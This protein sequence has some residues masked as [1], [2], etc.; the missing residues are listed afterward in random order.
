M[1]IVKYANEK[2]DFQKLNNFNN[3]SLGC[4]DKEIGYLP[5]FF[6]DKS[7]FGISSVQSVSLKLSRIKTENDFAII[8][9]DGYP[10]VLDSN[11]IPGTKHHAQKFTYVTDNIQVYPF[12]VP[13]ILDGEQFLVPVNSNETKFDDMLAFEYTGWSVTSPSFGVFIFTSQDYKSKNG[14]FDINGDIAFDTETLQIANPFDVNGDFYYFEEQATSIDLKGYY[15]YS[16]F[17]NETIELKSE[18][19]RILNEASEIP[20]SGYELL[21][22]PWVI[23]PND[24]TFL[25]RTA[26]CISQSSGLQVSDSFCEVPFLRKSNGDINA[27]QSDLAQA[28]NTKYDYVKNKSTEFIEPTTERQYVTQTERENIN[29]AVPYTGATSAVDLNSQLLT[30]RSLDNLD[31]AYLTILQ[32]ASLNVSYNNETQDGIYKN[33]FFDVNS[34]RFNYADTNSNLF[35]NSYFNWLE[36]SFS[37]A[38]DNYSSLLTRAGL[39][40]NFGDLKTTFKSFGIEYDNGSYTATTNFEILTGNRVL[41]FPDESGV[42]ATKEYGTLT[43]E[44]LTNKGANNGYCG[45]DSGGKVPLSNLPTTLLIYK[46]VW[47]ATSNTPTLL[48]TDLTKAGY[49]YNVSVAGTQF[50]I[51]FKLGD[52]A[53][54]NDS[55]VLE[56]SDN[57]DDVISVNGQQGV[58]VLTQDDIADGTNYKRVT[59]SEKNT[60]NAKQD[61]LTNPITGTGT[62]TQIAF[63]NGTTSLSS[64]ANFTFNSSTKNLTI[65]GGVSNLAIHTAMNKHGFEDYTTLNIPSLDNAGYS[66]YDSFVTC[67]NVGNINHFAAY[68]ARFQYAGSGNITNNC[69]GIGIGLTHSG[70]GVININRGVY[71]A[72]P[73]ITGAGSINYNYG[74]YIED[75]TTGAQLANYAIYVAGGKSQLGSTLLVTGTSPELLITETD[76]A[77]DSKQWD[78]LVNGGVL[79]HRIINDANSV[80]TTYMQ[81]WRS[82]TTISKIVFPN[83]NVA[84]GNLTPTSK[85]HL[86]SGNSVAS[87]TQYTAGT[88]TGQTLS[89]GTLIGIDANANTIIKNQENLPIKLYTNNLERFNIE[90]DGT[91]SANT[92]NYENLVTSDNDIPNRKF[93][94]SYVKSFNNDATIGV[95]TGDYATYQEAILNGYKRVLLVN[96]AT[97]T[98]DITIPTTND[99]YTIDSISKSIVLNFDTF[100]FNAPVLAQTNKLIVRNTSLKWGYATADSGN[101]LSKS[102]GTYSA[103]DNV[104]F[105]N[106]DISTNSGT[107]VFDIRVN[108]NLLAN[109]ILFENCTFTFPSTTKVFRM[110]GCMF[111]NCRFVTQSNND[112]YINKIN[113]LFVDGAFTSIQIYEGGVGFTGS[114]TGTVYT[115]DKNELSNI[116]GVNITLAV[117]SY[118]ANYSNFYVKNLSTSSTGA[119]GNFS[120][121]SFSGDV[122]TIGNKFSNIDFAGDVTITASNAEFTNCNTITTG[123]RFIVSGSYS[124]IVFTNCKSLDTKINIGSSVSYVQ[125]ANC[126]LI[127]SNDVIIDRKQTHTAGSSVTI[128]N[129]T[130]TLV[131]NPATVL[132]TLSITMP[133]T[134]NILDGHEV[135]LNFGGTI[136]EGNPVI[137]ALT[138]TANSGQTIARNTLIASAYGEDIIILK[139]IN[140]LSKWI[141]K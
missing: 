56:K 48:E 11:E 52:W 89:D 28:D 53:I 139:W 51:D 137:T 25:I 71:V 27:V 124:G 85:I 140:S 121:G 95:T 78:T 33:N 128:L 110:I 136:T 117:S 79:S 77:I 4:I 88:L 31:I 22:T 1:I 135:M 123:K 66:S 32:P 44:K 69:D 8:K 12:L 7:D 24:P 113:D 72:K 86:D 49:V 103:F 102:K 40:V 16:I 21:Y 98:I 112:I 101:L 73:N 20:I 74:I 39:E 91:L 131:V 97:E 80:A 119:K 108:S 59:Q 5:E 15:Y 26:K 62:D 55:G 18:I 126:S 94:L 96:N 9:D 42:L 41:S 63:F 132:A 29:N 106:C 61:A 68:Q 6:F 127:N 100:C 50:G 122:T 92:A 81:I 125:T 115:G 65:K 64:S 109:K 60:W 30:Q 57:S 45:L 75:V 70:T 138:L 133:P 84:F 23:D 99:T 54:Y 14:L 36:L 118:T 46:G 116:T 13:V 129:N 67:N 120:N 107:N 34:V 87:Y 82:G 38:N 58:I 111:K 134:A 130:D 19:F 43:Y 47:N 35:I 105:I 93:V 17:I 141:I 90:A 3:I 10:A 104:K 37:P 76:A 114:S 2:F 83:G